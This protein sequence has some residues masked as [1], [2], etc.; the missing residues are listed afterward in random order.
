VTV[1]GGRDREQAIRVVRAATAMTTDRGVAE[2]IV[3]AIEAVPPPA[4]E[5]SEVCSCGAELRLA[6][7]S[8]AAQERERASFRAAH[9]ECRP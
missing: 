9:E 1:L 4:G 6:S 7:L 2:R 3:D 8:L 5:S